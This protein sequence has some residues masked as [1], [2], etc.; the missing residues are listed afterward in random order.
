M[1]KYHAGNLCYIKLWH[2]WPLRVSGRLHLVMRALKSR[3]VS[4]SGGTRTSQTDSE[5]GDA[6]M[7]F[8]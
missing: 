6:L 4:P 8:S 2:T 5:H 7:Y 3:E 1:V